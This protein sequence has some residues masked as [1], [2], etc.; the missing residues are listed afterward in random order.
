LPSWP[1]WLRRPGWAHRPSA[2]QLIVTGIVLASGLVS[3]WNIGRAGYSTFY[4]TAT[5]S[6]TVSWRALAFGAFDPRA[7]ITLDKLAGFLVPQA[8]S[9]RLFGFHPWSI[10]LPQVLEGMVTVAAAAVI[11][12]RWKGPRAAV[13]AALAVASTPLLPSMF[14]HEMEDGLLTMSLALAMLCWQ[15]AVLHGRLR[16]LLLCA[17]WVAVGFQAKM[18][19]AWLIVPGLAIGYLLAAPHSLPR[20]FGRGALAG[21]VLF[22]LSVSWMTALQLVPA[23]HRPYIDGS[24][25]NNAFSMVFGYNGFN[26]LLPNLVPGAIGNTGKAHRAL[27]SVAPGLRSGIS[28]LAQHRPHPLPPGMR[29]SKL[30]LP[31][32]TTQVGWLYPAALVGLAVP[33]VGLIRRRRLVYTDRDG[34]ISTG[35]T[36]VLGSWLLLCAA[37]LTTASVPHTAYLAA[38]SVQVGLLASAGLVDA[39]RL[40]HGGGWPSRAVLPLLILAETLWTALILIWHGNAPGRLLP[41][42]LAIGLASSAALAVPG[43]YWRG[44]TASDGRWRAGLVAAGLIAVF[45]APLTWTGYV[46][47]PARN[48]TAG[49]AYTGP[50]PAGTAH[51]AAQRYRI[52]TPFSTPSD[53][54]LSPAQLRLI[55]YLRRHAGRSGPLM[56]TDQWTTA[57]VYILDGGLDVQTM[58][59]FSGRAPTPTL[60]QLQRMI[61]TGRLRFALLTDRRP[62]TEFN[63]VV[64]LD[65]GWLRDH[66]NPVQPS[67]YGGPSHSLLGLML[68]SCDQAAGNASGNPAS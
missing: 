35:T 14:G 49:E 47:D 53:P 5:H 51:A 22:G 16:S 31:Y 3:A 52:A 17:F 58:G 66:C 23:A 62:L 6:M 60:P 46:L 7:T 29:W 26:R 59:G 18:M 68:Y 54:R 21:S 27:K 9:A 41:A 33:L 56:I 37:V 63:Y 4:S 11:A 36:L 30:L 42:V 34:L 50:K 65:R 13:L 67:D 20:R 61:R 45:L 57:S 10:A 15:S 2:E 1:A 43:R 28:Q 12:H 8:L 39:I 48:G 55:D 24:T 25:N 40:Q 44:L 38:I 19:Q 64:Q 32:F